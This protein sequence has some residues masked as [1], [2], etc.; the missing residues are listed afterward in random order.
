MLL[1]DSIQ[2]FTADQFVKLAEKIEVLVKANEQ[3]IS[4]A[5]AV[6][7]KPWASY[8]DQLKDQSD[9]LASIAESF[10]MAGDDEALEILAFVA[11]ETQSAGCG[12]ENLV[13]SMHA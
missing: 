1:N 3:V 9:H 8:L 11:N 13:G 7:F 6:N 12:S 10:H 4:S 2:N 5:D